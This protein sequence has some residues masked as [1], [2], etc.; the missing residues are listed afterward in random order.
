MTQNRKVMILQGPAVKPAA[1]NSVPRH[2]QVLAEL[3][4][5]RKK[6]RWTP[7]MWAQ[8]SNVPLVSVQHVKA[9]RPQM[10]PWG[11]L[12]AMA[13]PLGTD[14]RV[15]LL[16]QRPPP[17]KTNAKILA[18]YDRLLKSSHCQQFWHAVPDQQFQQLR[19]DVAGDAD[20]NWLY[21]VVT[22]RSLR[23][24]W[25]L[26]T[27]EPDGWPIKSQ[28]HGIDSETEQIAVELADHLLQKL[29]STAKQLKRKEA[30][31]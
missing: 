27:D 9:G 24:R 6:R 17:P 23:R 2:A 22:H 28:V 14:L 20:R 19:W 21:A 3:V 15:A 18:A 31:P 7:V 10:V 13:V 26:V 12:V 16:Y 29:P 8:R 4:W 11:H 30:G 1:G 25:A 5:E